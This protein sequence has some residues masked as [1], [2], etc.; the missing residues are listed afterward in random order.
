VQSINHLAG[1]AD[2]TVNGVQLDQLVAQ[3]RELVRSVTHLSN[4]LEHEPT[5]LIFG[6]RRKGYIPQ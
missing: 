6:D 1:D 2:K 5:Q 3:T 4:Q